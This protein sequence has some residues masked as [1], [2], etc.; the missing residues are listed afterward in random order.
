MP[1]SD[2][3]YHGDFPLFRLMKVNNI[4]VSLVQNKVCSVKKN[5]TKYFSMHINEQ[6]GFL[7]E[8]CELMFS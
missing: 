8:S 1:N 6:Y 3:L 4:I 2:V 7:G 5:E